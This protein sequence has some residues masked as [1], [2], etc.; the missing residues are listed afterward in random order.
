MTIEAKI[1]AD[2]LAP[3]GVRLTTFVLKYPRF[4]HAELM[5]NRAFSRNASSSRA[6][7]FKRKA[8]SLLTEMAMPIQFLKNKRGM[9]GGEPLPLLKQMAARS[10]W[11]TAGYTAL[12]YAFLL[13]KLGVS[14]QY[15]NRIT[16]PIDFITVIV[17]A[18][19]WNNFFALRIHSAAQPEI[20]K[21]AE[22]MWHELQRSQP[23]AL[24]FGEWH[25]PFING[26]DW[27]GTSVEWRNWT[28]VHKGAYTRMIIGKQCGVARKAN[29]DIWLPLIKQSVAKCARVSY[30]NHDG[31]NTTKEQNE[32]LYDRLVG[33]I[34]RHSSAA[35]H[36]ARANMSQTFHGNFLSWEQYRKMLDNEFILEFDGTPLG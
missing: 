7:P 2:S 8:K 12:G 21:L 17:T 36:Q 9:Q 14:K 35:E 3:S 32:A 25:L 33:S 29:M 26:K 27:F 5:T 6:I 10:V 13:Y 15:V 4:I 16:E 30:N 28:R 19:H 34:P 11:K 24:A 1:I 23:Q 22:T 18:T 31:S 20:R